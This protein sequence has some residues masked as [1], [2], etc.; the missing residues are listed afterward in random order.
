VVLEESLNITDEPPEMLLSKGMGSF[1]L[2]DKELGCRK[3]VKEF[4][5]DLL[6]K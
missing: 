1:S 4:S 6:W 2:L 5:I 3:I